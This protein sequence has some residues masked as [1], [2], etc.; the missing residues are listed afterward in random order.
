MADIAKCEGTGCPLK[1][2]CYRYRALAGDYW[3]SWLAKVP[4]DHQT[5]TCDQ[6]W[7]MYDQRK[8]PDREN[9]SEK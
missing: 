2:T 6:Y 1:D 4:Y 9:L 3:Q 7:K 8:Q 5:D